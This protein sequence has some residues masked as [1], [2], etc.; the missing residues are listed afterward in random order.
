M[1]L[2]EKFFM[3]L[4]C[5]EFFSHFSHW[6]LEISLSLSLSLSLSPKIHEIIMSERQK[7]INLNPMLPFEGKN[8]H[9]I[10]QSG[11]VIEFTQDQT[12]VETNKNST[13][14]TQNPLQIDGSTY[15]DIFNKQTR[16]CKPVFT[17]TRILEI[18]NCYNKWI[19]LILSFKIIGLLWKG[20]KWQPIYQKE[21][22]L[23][24]CSIWICNT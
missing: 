8:H 4:S 10:R 22:T 18:N 20:I 19:T 2:S 21:Y 3:S 11:S 7:T 6:L 1:K 5:K 15:S 17:K 12:S 9:N 14:F 24:K 23:N 16:S 13:E